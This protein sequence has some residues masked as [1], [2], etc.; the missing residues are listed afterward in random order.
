MGRGI[1]A[2]VDTVP[3]R[4]G[5]TQPGPLGKASVSLRSDPDGLDVDELADAV[6][7]QLAAVARRLTPPKGSRGSD[8]TMPLMNTDAGLDA[9]GEPPRAVDVARQEAAAEPVG[10]VG[11]RVPR[12]RSASRARISGATGPKTSSCATG[13]S[14]DDVR[15]ARS[16]G[17]SSRARSI[18]SPPHDD[19]RARGHRSLDLAVRERRAGRRGPAARS[20]V[21]AIGRI[22]DARA[23]GR[24]RRSARGIRRRRPSTMKRLAAMQLWPA[25]WKRAR[26]PV[27][28]AAVEV[29]VGEHDEGVGAAELEHRLLHGA[30]GLPRRRSRR[31]RRCRSASR[32][33][34]AGRRSARPARRRRSAGLRTHRRGIRRVE[35]AP[36]SP[37]RTA[38]RWR[39][40]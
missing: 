26:T 29:G 24:R 15:R 7:R 32:R 34:C 9:A 20:A 27:S 11:W 5:S 6:L 1:Q 3:G 13:I 22:A 37:A 8:A 28:T 4:Q 35:R 33:R 19:L 17:R 12:R 31:R 18:R 30:T 23:A 10:R 39:R 36:R 2:R 14:G 25:F 38:A 16:A 40:A 21:A